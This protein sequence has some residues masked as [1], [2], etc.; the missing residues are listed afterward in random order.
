M[1]LPDPKSVIAGYITDGGEKIQ[2]IRT[3]M[4]FEKNKR[5]DAGW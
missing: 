4:L 2:L 5:A 1:P 3:E